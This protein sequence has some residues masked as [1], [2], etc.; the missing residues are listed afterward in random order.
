MGIAVYII[1]LGAAFLTFAIS[2]G[3]LTDASRRIGQSQYLSGNT[4]LQ[5]A[6]KWSIIAAVVAW[7]TI[8]LMIIGTILAVIYGSEILFETGYYTYFIYGLLFL[9]LIGT[10]VVGVLGALTASDINKAGL[11]EGGDNGAYKQAIIATVVAIIVFVLLLVVI[12][13]KLFYK[14]KSKTDKEIEQQEKLLSQKQQ[15]ASV[16]EELPNSPSWMKDASESDQK[17]AAALGQ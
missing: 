14:P 4:S 13:I 8:A 10:I 6:H 2:A 3:F 5:A 7:I 9:S 17:L 1:F 11:P 12:G 15:E 16:R